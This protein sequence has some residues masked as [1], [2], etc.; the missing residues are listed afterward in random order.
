VLKNRRVE[1]RIPEKRGR[2]SEYQSD[3]AAES[4]GTKYIL[5]PR[6]QT[7]AQ[8]SD[9]GSTNTAYG[10]GHVERGT[11]QTITARQRDSEKH[12]HQIVSEVRTA[13]P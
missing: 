5:S 2:W 3:N 8:P 7:N 4:L 1:G 10:S 6:T 9:D 12:W 13:L 11:S